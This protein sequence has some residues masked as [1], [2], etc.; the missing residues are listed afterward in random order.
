M[1][2]FEEVFE[3]IKLATNA[4]T[5][6][7]LAEVLGIRQS[8]ISDAKR[9]N[10]IPSDWYMKLFEKFGL[11]PDWL[12]EGDGPMYLKTSDGGYTPYDGPMAA[13]VREEAAHYAEPESKATV[14]TVYS[15]ECQPGANQPGDE[16]AD[17]SAIGSFKLNPVGKLAVPQS[18]S[19]PS[20][21]VFRM[22]TGSMEPVVNR[23]AFIG[24]DRSQ[25][26]LRSGELFMIHMPYENGLAVKRVFSDTGQ[27][28]FILR[29][30]NE[31]HPED[32]LPV[33]E[34]EARVFG[35]VLWVIQRF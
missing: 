35:R 14:A 21:V 31:S 13:R 30:E 18:L 33:K 15:L 32:Y 10:S 26:S 16:T 34:Q 29:S 8:S 3:R 17:T 20:T 6:V 23:N 25:T 27:A 11:N 9:R 24:V 28:R 19:G 4:K 2:H 22:D 12:K 1:S 7:A 5:Q